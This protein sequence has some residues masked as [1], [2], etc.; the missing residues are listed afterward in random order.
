MSIVRSGSDTNNT[1]A[2]AKGKFEKLPGM[3]LVGSHRYDL[4]IWS[5]IG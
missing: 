3:A 1:R 5:D 2:S 4:D